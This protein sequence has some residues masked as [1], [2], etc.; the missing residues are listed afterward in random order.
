MS[1]TPVSDAEMLEQVG[2]R[3]LGYP[4]GAYDPRR[5]QQVIRTYHGPVSVT[6]LDACWWVRALDRSLSWELDDEA[7]AQ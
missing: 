4:S 7:G 2:V 3:L 1:C 6:A 5:V